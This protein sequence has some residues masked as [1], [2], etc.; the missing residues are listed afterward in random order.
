[1]AIPPPPRC[2]SQTPRWKRRSAAGE[3]AAGAEPAKGRG[4]CGPSTVGFGNWAEMERRGGKGQG[5][6]GVTRKDVNK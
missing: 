5:S 1:V 6:V 2:Q 4:A 3:A